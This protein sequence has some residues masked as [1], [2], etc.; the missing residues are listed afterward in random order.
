MSKALKD[1]HILRRQQRAEL[2]RKDSHRMKTKAE[3]QQEGMRAV[4][5]L[6]QGRREQRR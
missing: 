1:S 2:R 6:V 4:T 3:L 5:W